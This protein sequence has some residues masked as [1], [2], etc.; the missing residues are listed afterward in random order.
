M[1][2]SCRCN[3]TTGRD[4][5]IEADN[6][7]DSQLRAA[8]RFLRNTW[9][10]HKRLNMDRNMISLWPTYLA[11]PWNI[12]NRRLNF[13]SFKDCRVWCVP[14]YADDVSAMV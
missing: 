12:F 10:S 1:L 2:V 3:A 13:G 9:G 8:S 4:P 14:L 6:W 5:C 11:S 7:K